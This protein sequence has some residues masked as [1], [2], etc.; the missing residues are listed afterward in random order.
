MKDED[1]G[2]FLMKMKDTNDQEPFWWRDNYA[3]GSTSWATVKGHISCCADGVGLEV[4][5]LKVTFSS[6]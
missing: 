5:D 1:S 2:L 4:E 3:I 6:V